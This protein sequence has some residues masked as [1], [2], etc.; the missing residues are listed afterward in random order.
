MTISVD[1]RRDVD[2]AMQ[3]A[4]VTALK[5]SA[6][7]AALVGARI[8]DRVPTGA[9]FP[10]VTV[11]DIQIVEDGAE[12]IVADELFLDLHVWDRDAAGVGTMRL[13]AIAGALRRTLDGA[14]LALGQHHVLVDLAYQGQRDAG[15]DDPLTRHLVVSFRALTETN[16]D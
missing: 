15:S 2:G 8:Y 7:V 6:E 14:T 4:L 10:Y 16:D 9:T 1:D 3:V 5:A 12:G 13:K 11:P